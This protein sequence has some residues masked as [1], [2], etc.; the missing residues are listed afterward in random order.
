M[1]SLLSVRSIP[2]YW[3]VYGIYS[4]YRQSTDKNCVYIIYSIYAVSTVYRAL[5]QDAVDCL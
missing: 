5:F 2:G 1:L 3:I 4:V